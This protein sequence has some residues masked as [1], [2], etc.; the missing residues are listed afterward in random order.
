MEKNEKL[1]TINQVAKFCSTSRSTIMRMEKDG[2]LT[3]AYVN[4][5]TGYRYY[6][7]KEVLRILRNL[8]LG[9]VGITHRELA[10]YY[11]GTESYG[12][13]LETLEKKEKEL[14]D[15]L[16]ILRVQTGQEM[17]LHTASYDFSAVYCYTRV[18]K[19]V[20][21]PSIIRG[22]MWETV[23]ETIEKGYSLQ[24][25][26]QPFI[27][28]NPTQFLQG[29]FSYLKH[30][31]TVNV[32]ILWTGGQLP[33]NV[34]YYPECH[35]ISALLYGGNGDIAKAF[36]RLGEQIAFRKFV[37]IGDARVS[38]IVNSYPGEDIPMEYWVSRV[39]IPIQRGCER[40]ADNL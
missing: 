36:T 23:N 16:A 6:K 33:E 30:D 12:N 39:C 25:E 20:E 27:S 37:P 11:A 4:D 7:T 10:E 24:R 34:V 17:H 35:T 38:A 14:R 26:V 9:G 22:L 19:D 18:I 5:E 8:S 21:R 15:L 13:L 40:Q 29:D 28:V 31:Y 2:I 32:P 3:P 1:Y